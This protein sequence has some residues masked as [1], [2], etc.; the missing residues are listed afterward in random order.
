RA[1]RDFQ[2]KVA[3]Y[4]KSFPDKKAVPAFLSV[5]GFTRGALQFCKENGVGTA[6]GIEFYQK[7]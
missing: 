7:D 1:V 6:E 4:S 5:G 3:A 2:E